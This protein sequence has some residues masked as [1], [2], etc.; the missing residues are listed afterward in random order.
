MKVPFIDLAPVVRLAR[1]QALQAF[2]RVVDQSEFVGGPSVASLEATLARKLGVTHAVTCA[3]GSDALAIALASLGIGP[4][5]RVGV[6]NLTF[7]ATFEAVVRLGAT[8]VLID[9]DP[10]NLQMDF[11]EL[12]R[13]HEALHLSGAIL[14]HLMGWAT[15]RLSDFRAFC[16]QH[17]IALLEDGAQAYG[18]QVHGRSVFTGARMSTLSFYPAKVIGG[19]M[20]GGAMLTDDPA[21]A[22]VARKLCNHGRATHY[23]YGDIGWN[24]RMGGLQAE[25]LLAL[26]DHDDRIL[27]Q[28][29]AIEASYREA[30]AGLA[31]HVVPFGPAAGVTGNAYLSV[32]T[33]AR[34]PLERVR[35]HLAELGIGVGHVYPETMDMQPPAAS[36]PRVGD[37]S[38]AKS[39]CQ[40]VINLPLFYGMT[41]DQLGYVMDALHAATK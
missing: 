10:S 20:N 18:V 35:A 34:R 41:D 33:L 15:P 2:E 23:T 31:G 30:F 40:T 11:D 25:W 16:G 19:C 12:V 37:L 4:G 36:A 9:V 6:P 1:T 38:N 29:R 14:V 27:A 13:T 8:P 39:F 26:L 17:G 28:R 5:M 32:A 21:L 3:S 22:S 7:W 24:S